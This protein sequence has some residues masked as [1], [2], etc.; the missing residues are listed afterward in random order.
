[1][2]GG[3]DGRKRGMEKGRGF[4]GFLKKNL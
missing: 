4:H 3:R 2:N 1:V